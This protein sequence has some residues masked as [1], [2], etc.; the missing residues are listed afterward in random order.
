[1]EP[2]TATDR[3]SKVLSVRQDVK[4]SYSHFGQL[5]E[6]LLNQD[7]GKILDSSLEKL[8]DQFRHWSIRIPDLSGQFENPEDPGDGLLYGPEHIHR[9]NALLKDLHQAWTN[10]EEICRAPRPKDFLRWA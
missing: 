7:V 8:W 2:T 9:A 10:K 5:F 3:N 6:N 1:M 4:Q